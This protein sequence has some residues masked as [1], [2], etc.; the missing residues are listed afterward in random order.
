MVK[1][2]LFKA[3]LYGKRQETICQAAVKKESTSACATWLTD[4]L[5]IYR[6]TQLIAPD[7]WSYQQVHQICTGFR[8]LVS[9]ALDGQN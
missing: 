6:P 3:K 7:L 8:Q 5:V 4:K 1:S 2:G 9:A